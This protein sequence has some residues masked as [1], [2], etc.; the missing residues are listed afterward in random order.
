MRNIILKIAL[1]AAML[2]SLPAMGKT[3][4]FDNYSSDVSV[5][6][7]VRIIIDEGMTKM[8][9]KMQTASMKWQTAELEIVKKFED[10]FFFS[11]EAK[12]AYGGL[13]HINVNFDDSY[14]GMFRSDYRKSLE[15]S[16]PYKVIR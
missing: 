4:Y 12:D 5:Y 13:W 9:V 14:I 6:R 3:Y 7:E 16:S 8:T 2:V 10:R 1:V 15:F 11:C